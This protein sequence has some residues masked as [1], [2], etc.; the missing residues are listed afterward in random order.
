[1]P[2]CERTYCATNAFFSAAPA[3]EP[4]VI[5]NIQQQ[6]NASGM[7]KMTGEVYWK[8]ALPFGRARRPP[9]YPG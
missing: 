5:E 3:L 9:K 2:V 4:S 8:N 1:M 6:K 7:V